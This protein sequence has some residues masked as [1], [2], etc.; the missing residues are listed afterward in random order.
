MANYAVIE[1]NIVINTIIA[2]S[3]EIAEQISEQTCIEYTD[4]NPAIIGLGY[5]DGIFEQPSAIVIEETE[6]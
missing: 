3:K 4:E 2:E 1:D 6:G 5:S